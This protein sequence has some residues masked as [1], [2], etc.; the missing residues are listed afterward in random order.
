[1][2]NAGGFIPVWVIYLI[3][4]FLFLSPAGGLSITAF[5]RILFNFGV[6]IFTS[7]DFLTLSIRSNIF[8]IFFPVFAETKTTGAKGMKLNLRFRIGRYFSSASSAASILFT[9]K[10]IPF[11][12]SL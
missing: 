9:I 1:M 2:V 6:G 7:L 4:G 12:E 5:S 8:W 10:I 11:R 3:F